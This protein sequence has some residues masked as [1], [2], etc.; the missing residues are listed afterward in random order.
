MDF[1]LIVALVL[2]ASG[3]FRVVLIRSGKL[4]EGLGVQ[5]YFPYAF[6]AIGVLMF[7][8]ALID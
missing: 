3:A 8:A 6:I 1:T 4:P 2:I 7:V 5:K